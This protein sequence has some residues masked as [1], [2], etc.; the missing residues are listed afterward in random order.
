MN[1]LPGHIH[2]SVTVLW[3]DLAGHLA[4]TWENIVLSAQ[5]RIGDIPADWEVP[6]LAATI[7]DWRAND[8]S[9]RRYRAFRR[10]CGRSARRKP[11]EGVIRVERANLTLP[12]A[13]ALPTSARVRDGYSQ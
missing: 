7:D 10:S 8:N 11:G 12:I 6:D 3:A 9:G 5:Q 1:L 2:L 4:R 13:G